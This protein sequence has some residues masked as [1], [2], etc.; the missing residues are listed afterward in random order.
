[1]TDLGPV[2]FLVTRDAL[3]YLLNPEM[4]AIGSET[5][6]E[7]FFDFE[8]DIHRIARLEFLKRLGGEPPILLTIDDVEAASL[9]AS[10]HLDD[11]HYT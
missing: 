1:M 4:D 10:K 11:D 3:A 7:T 9:P 6:I 8:S 2:D 5:A